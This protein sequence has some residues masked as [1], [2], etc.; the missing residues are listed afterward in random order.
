MLPHWFR[1]HP[2]LSLGLSSFVLLAMLTLELPA[3]A[4]FQRGLATSLREGIRAGTK[5][6][7][8]Q[9][10]RGLATVWRV[11]GFGPHRAANF[12]ARRAPELPEWLDTGLVVL[13]GLLPY[14]AADALLAYVRRGRSSAAP[15]A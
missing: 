10:Q 3:D 15:P 11:A 12:L 4:Q 9:F 2:F 1:R 8:A 5:P 6:A 7:D 13:L 14:L